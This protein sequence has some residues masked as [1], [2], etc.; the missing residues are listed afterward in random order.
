ML[1]SPGVLSLNPQQHQQ[2]GQ[3]QAQHEELLA[4]TMEGIKRLGSYRYSTSMLQDCI[5]S[6][7]QT[8]PHS[9]TV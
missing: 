1:Q 6:L 8:Y 7:Q 2:P 5:F 4:S 3:L 9:T